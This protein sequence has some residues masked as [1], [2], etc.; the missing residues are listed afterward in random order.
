MAAKNHPHPRSSQAASSPAARPDE[1]RPVRT[2]DAHLD[3]L[4]E[5][6]YAAVSG[7][8]IFA[9]VLAAVSVVAFL[10]APL[11]LP[12]PMTWLRLPIL[13]V[14]PLTAIAASLA[15]WRSIRRSE[16]TRTGLRLAQAALAL[17]LVA[18]LGSGAMHA[19][20]QV[21]RYELQ[22][23]LVEVANGYLQRV[24]TDQPDIIFG[25]LVRNGVAPLDEKPN[26]LN[27]WKTAQYYMHEGSGDYY[28]LR[29]EK[30]GAFVQS[31]APKDRP[32][33]EEILQDF[34]EVIYRLQYAKGAIDLRFGFR[35]VEGQWKLINFN[36]G[37]ALE[38]PKDGAQPKKRFEP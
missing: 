38:L 24:L 20:G 3:R 4:V 35:L 8:A 5:P 29:L 18:T 21:H 7:A 22:R 30:A 25:D 32:G 31:V 37:F 36:Q 16:G 15:A 11:D 12:L 14:L 28:G 9:L 17:A 2:D 27:A 13:L 6:E 19:V 23:S 1:P 10:P 26:Y 34:G 33:E